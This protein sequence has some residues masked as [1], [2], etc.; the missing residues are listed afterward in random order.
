MNKWEGQHPSGQGL[1]G[2]SRLLR[3]DEGIA[4]ELF[5]TD[6]VA[7]NP[8]TLWAFIDENSAVADGPPDLA[9][10]EIRINVDG[11]FADGAGEADGDGVARFSGFVPAGSL[12]SFN[13]KSVLAIDD[14]S[15]DDPEEADIL[16]LVRLHGSAIAG[17]EFEQTTNVNGGCP[18]NTC[19][20][21]QEALHGGDDDDDDS[22]SDSDSDD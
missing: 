17:E 13:G 21:I 14:G 6:L 9:P 18:P 7:G 22:D 2:T 12:P 19:T 10:F 11:L 4:F 1:F 15:F 8:Y 3:T 20:T 16:L 5:T